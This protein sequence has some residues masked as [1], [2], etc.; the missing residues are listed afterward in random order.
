MINMARHGQ[1]EDSMARFK[2]RRGALASTE[3][4]KRT[5][6]HHNRAL[7]YRQEELDERYAELAAAHTPKT[8][9]AE[10]NAAARQVLQH[11]LAVQEMK[12]LW[13]GQGRRE[14][15]EDRSRRQGRGGSVSTSAQFTAIAPSCA[16]RGAFRGRSLPLQRAR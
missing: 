10:R 16:R 9:R 11:G 2:T 8:G 6:A 7:S 5:A 14:I 3:G 13:K 1:R 4:H 15:Q 12:K